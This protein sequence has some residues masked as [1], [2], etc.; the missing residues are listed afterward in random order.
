MVKRVLTLGVALF[1]FSCGATRQPVKTTVSP[2]TL[3]KKQMAE[4]NRKLIEEKVVKPNWSSSPRVVYAKPVWIPPVIRRIYIPPHVA[5]D[6]SMVAGYYVWKIVIPGRWRKP[7]EKVG[8]IPVVLNYRSP[9]RK[10]QEVRPQDA[11]AI[12]NFLKK[13]RRRK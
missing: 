13:F 8:E 11:E 6:G 1:L 2:L 12:L 9:E 10:E 4:R 3:E 7:G 5:P